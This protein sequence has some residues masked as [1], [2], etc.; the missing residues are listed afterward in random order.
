MLSIIY[1]KV[2]SSVL[3]AAILATTLSVSAFAANTEEEL[4]PEQSLYGYTFTREYLSDDKMELYSYYNGELQKKYTI[5]SGEPLIYV[6][7]LK[8]V[9]S[10]A[11]IRSNYT[12][13]KPELVKTSP[14][15]PY[16]ERWAILGFINYE[17][18]STLG[19][20]RGYTSAYGNTTRGSF[21]LNERPGTP[22]DDIVALLESFLV[23]AGI[24]KIAAMLG[25]S[26]AGWAPA[27]LASI[28]AT[29]SIEV[30]NG[31]IDMWLT[32]TVDAIVT[33]WDFKVS[34]FS[35]NDNADGIDVILYD[36]GQTVT[37]MHTG[38][39]EWDK[40]EY[41]ITLNKWKSST[42]ALRAWNLMFP[43]Y[44]CPGVSSYTKN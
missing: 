39:V 17:E 33:S 16:A 22:L 43:G 24:A 23:D 4:T 36:Q 35:D 30:V 42:L 44:Q 40:L 1:K 6:E 20:V 19:Y 8:E 34:S 21:A 10:K 29:L 18:H 12:I 3:A 25:V 5:E 14:I 41:G 7:V 31:C 37:V 13:T 27:L 2:I 9:S 38:D 28:I 26:I 15:V 11:A 32:D